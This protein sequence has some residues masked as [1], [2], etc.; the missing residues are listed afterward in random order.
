MNAYMHICI[1]PHHNTLRVYIIYLH[2]NIHDMTS[3]HITSRYI[4]PHYIKHIHTYIHI[5]RHAY[6]Q[7][8]TYMYH[9]YH[10][11]SPFITLR[12]I[13]LHHMASH[14]ITSQ[15]IAFHC[16]HTCTQITH[17]MHT[18]ATRMHSHIHCM[19][20]IHACM[21]THMHVNIHAQ[22]TY[23]NKYI[24]AF[25]HTSHHITWRRITHTHTCPTCHTNNITPHY[26]THIAYTHM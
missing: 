25:I 1:T 5:F 3:H 12:C 26:V 7:I 13:T 24:D 11:T 19:H 10:I 14:H 6:L 22:D 20:A 18:C 8:R 21:H 2:M 17:T 16:A 4:T 15:Y 23:L 9:I